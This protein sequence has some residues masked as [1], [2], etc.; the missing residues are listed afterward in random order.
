[1]PKAE[2]NIFDEAVYQDAT[3]TVA[4]GINLSSLPMPW[5][6]FSTK[7]NPESTLANKC[8]TPTITFDKGT[9]KF[10]CSTSGV[11]FVSEIKVDDAGKRTDA[12]IELHK[13]YVI[14]VY[15]RK[16]GWKNSDTTEGTIPM[17]L[18]GDV[19]GDGDITA[20]DASLILQKVAKKITLPSMTGITIV[21]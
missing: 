7:S 5:Y 20:Q 8:A 13:S 12:S 1:M 9:I 21:K 14:R 3:L 10:A 18:I 6:N 2:E 15:A 4:K 16:E 11:T 19:N 17:D